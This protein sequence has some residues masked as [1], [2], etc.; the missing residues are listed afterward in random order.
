MPCRSKGG[1]GG[2]RGGPNGDD[3]YE[4]KNEHVLRFIY[5]LQFLQYHL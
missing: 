4:K 3:T 5:S 2:G 1:G